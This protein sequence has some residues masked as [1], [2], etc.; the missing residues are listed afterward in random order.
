VWLDKWDIDYGDNILSK[1]EEGLRTSRFVAVVLS[2]AFTRAD[3]PAM[4]WQT[5]VYADPAGKSGRILPILLHKFDAE[6]GDAA[7]DHPGVSAANSSTWR[8]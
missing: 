6:T 8:R 3:W 2:P 7:R 1:I 4:E 5:Q